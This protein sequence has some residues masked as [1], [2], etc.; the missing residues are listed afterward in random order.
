MESHS[1]PAHITVKIPRRA[2]QLC[3]DKLPSGVTVLMVPPDAFL[4]EFIHMPDGKDKCP[5]TGMSRTWLLER[6][7]ESQK[8]NYPIKAHHIREKGRLRGVILID[9]AS[10]VTWVS[11][12]PAPSWGENPRLR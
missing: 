8:S 9:R 7:R 2:L 5:V 6:I 1:E 3:A 10:L 4:P 11:E 12:Q